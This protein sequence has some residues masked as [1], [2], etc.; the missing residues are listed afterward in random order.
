VLFV[1]WKGGFNADQGTARG[2]TTIERMGDTVFAE[3]NNTLMHFYGT[4][5]FEHIELYYD[6]YKAHFMQLGP[7]GSFS[8]KF[9]PLDL[10][11]HC[12]INFTGRRVFL[13]EF[14]VMKVG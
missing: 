11:V 7:S 13:D 5:G 4:M 9:H 3:D 1:T 8:T 10:Y 14:K 6:R 12:H 2:L